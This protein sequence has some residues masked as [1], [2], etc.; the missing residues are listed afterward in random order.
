[1]KQFHNSFFNHKYVQLLI[2]TQIRIFFILLWLGCLTGFILLSYVSKNFAQEKSLSVYMWSDKI[3]ES[4]LQAFEQET[5]I[6]IYVNYYESNEELVTKF[7]IAKDLNCDIILPSEYIIEPLAKSGF[8]KKIDRSQCHFIDRI[9]PEFMGHQFDIDNEYS[10][11]IYFD[12]LGLGYTHSYFQDGLPSNSWN[13]IF[14]KD[15]VPCKQISMV[16]DSREAIFLTLKYFGWDTEQLNQ[17]QL[18][19]IEKL[20]LE[21]KKWVGAYTDFQQSY[22]L[23]SKTYPLVV[24]QRERVVRAMI[25][26]DDLGFTIPDEGS[27]MILTNVV[28]SASTQ[29]DEMIYQFLNYIYDHDVMMSNCKKFCILPVVKDVLEDLPQE[30]VGV[31]SLRPG[32]ELFQRLEIFKNI[33][34]QKQINDIWIAFKSF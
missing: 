7:E 1:M 21:Q 15:A 29:K 31:D 2:K 5:G 13:L 25:T 20:F 26:D 9:Y 3:D 11:P 19:T 23:T 27:L 8:L 24:S 16:D 12:I 33:L 32:Q 30:Y 14:N 17:E 10:L 18:K 22:F 6:K 34:T 4:V 28:I